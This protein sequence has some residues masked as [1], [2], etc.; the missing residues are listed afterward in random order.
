M[1][2]PWGK[3][4]TDVLRISSSDL[5][6][7]DIAIRI[8]E[9]INQRYLGPMLVIGKGFPNNQN[10]IKPGILLRLRPRLCSLPN[11]VVVDSVVVERIVQ[12]CLSPGFRA[13]RINVIGEIWIG[14]GY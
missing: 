6:G 12:W 2:H 7:F 5:L 1:F 9:G 4:V 14:Y 11:D 10:P 8:D 3:M 13:V